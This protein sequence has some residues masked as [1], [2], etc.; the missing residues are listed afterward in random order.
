[1]EDQSADRRPHLAVMI[2][3][4]ACCI[5]QMLLILRLNINWDEYWFLGRIYLANAG[6]LRDPFQNFHVQ[7]LGWIAWL[8]LGAI[9]Q[10][11]AGRFVM[12]FCQFA[13]LGC[14][15]WIARKLADGPS[16][17]V[18]VVLYFGA[19]Y[20]LAHGASFR[21]DPP[22]AAAMMGALA[23]L[24]AKPKWWRSVLAGSLA[25]ISLLITVKAVFYLP[26][27]L[28]ALLFSWR[29][30]GAGRVLFHFALAGA[31]TLIIGLFLWMW[32][33]ATLTPPA[34]QGAASTAAPAAA[35]GLERG[36]AASSSA[37][38]KVIGEQGWFPRARYI[39]DWIVGGVVPALAIAAGAALS[40]RSLIVARKRGL[41]ITLL[42]C[43]LPLVTLAFYRNAYAYY[44]PFILFP[45]LLVALPAVQ[46]LAQL[47]QPILQM[48]LLAVLAFG[49]IGQM[50]SYWPRVQ[51]AQRAYAAAVQEMFPEP[52]TY[53][54][55]S[56]MFP[57]NHKSGFFMSSW[58][59][60][61]S[62]LPGHPGIDD[63]IRRDSPPLMMLTSPALLKAA[64]PEFDYDSP[65]LSTEDEAMVLAHYIEHWGDIWVAGKELS[66]KSGQFEIIIAGVYTLECTG[67]RTLAGRLRRCGDVVTLAKGQT[68][69][70][71]GPVTLRWG[72]NLPKPQEAPPGK[73]S[74]Y[75]L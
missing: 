69:W 25:A 58:G 39:N 36:V 5:A 38:Q 10:I 22:A 37:A 4:A 26:A 60:E 29:D 67:E 46:R 9:D 45:A 57:S 8:P 13:G 31:A 17:L 30:H 24:F 2:V 61:S 59:I 15:Y 23:L 53:I 74:Y 70:D 20:S 47:R 1:M 43:A 19:T 65:R 27:F 12:L 41:A 34:L 3:L 40:V 11:I 28:G 51:D 73:P 48:G 18:I 68:S 62:N 72:A 71:G 55:R 66:G 49:M 50:I 54:A 6:E 56:S 7:L 21:T 44:F 14:L 64:K 35:N 32:H 63:A 75:R 16:A 42:L 33:S 52:V